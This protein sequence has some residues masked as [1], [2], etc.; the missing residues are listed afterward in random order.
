[1]R[2]ATDT[3]RVTYGCGP[4]LRAEVR[5]IA[6][7]FPGCGS[8]CPSPWPKVWQ[9]SYARKAQVNQAAAFGRLHPRRRL[10][11]HAVHGGRCIHDSCTSFIEHSRQCP[12]LAFRR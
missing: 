5:I 3:A 2:S 6:A 10:H 8:V 9:S 4:T 1:M 12:Q 7:R 11:A